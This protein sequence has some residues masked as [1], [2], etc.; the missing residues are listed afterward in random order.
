MFYANK[1]EEAKLNAEWERS[2]IQTWH[3]LN[4]QLDRKNKI[5][6][7][8]FKKFFWPFVWERPE[9]IE[10]PDINWEER[11]RRDQERQMKTINTEIIEL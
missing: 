5:T 6:Y 2:R 11:D 10:V 8:Q 9:N 7:D 4:I 3:L 1:N